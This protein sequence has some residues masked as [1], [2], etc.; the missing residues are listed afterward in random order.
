MRAKEP[1]E[2]AGAGFA[3]GERLSYAGEKISLEGIL[4][5]KSDF[6]DPDCIVL[7]LGSGYNVGLDM[8]GA[9]HFRLHTCL[10]PLLRTYQGFPDIGLEAA[11]EENL[12]LFAVIFSDGV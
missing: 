8:R 7:K 6:S 2:E 9:F 1:K 10:D 11:Q 5:P 12:D 3:P 4:M